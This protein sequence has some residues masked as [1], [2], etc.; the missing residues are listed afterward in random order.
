MSN[1][2]KE[3]EWVRYDTDK[4]HLWI[5]SNQW[6]SLERFMRVK[7]DINTEMIMLSREVKRLTEENE[8]YK[9]LLRDKLNQEVKSCG[10]NRATE[11]LDAKRKKVQFRL[12]DKQVEMLDN[13]SKKT[14]RNKTDIFVDLMTKEY[15]RVIRK[16]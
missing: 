15:G 3:L 11:K 14:G 13:I 5:G 6:V 8:A 7:S 16:E 4:E 9:V 1:D 2:G 12:K 10:K